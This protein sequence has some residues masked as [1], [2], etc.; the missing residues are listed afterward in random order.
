LLAFSAN[1]EQGS[2]SEDCDSQC[3]FPIGVLSLLWNSLFPRMASRDEQPE[4]IENEDLQHMADEGNPDAQF[5][6]ARL[7]ELGE[8]LPMGKSRAA[9]YHKLSADQGGTIRRAQL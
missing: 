4:V 9:H 7:L 6:Y 1:R 2:P 8:R 5:N 3:E